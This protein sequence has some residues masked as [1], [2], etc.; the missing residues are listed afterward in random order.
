MTLDVT[1]K[2]RVALVAEEYSKSVLPWVIGFSGGKDSSLVV[3]IFCE[4]LA[5]LRTRRVPVH[6]VYCDTGVEIPVVTAFVRKTLKGIQQESARSNLPIRCHIA[7]PTLSDT[8][9]V[10]LIGRGYPP[11]TNKFRWCTDKLRIRPIQRLMAGVA[12]NEN[13]V[14]LGVRQAE[15]EERKRVLS[16]HSTAEKFYYQQS[17]CESRRLF[18]PIVD[19]D[20]STVWEGLFSLQRPQAIDVYKLGH[21]YKQ[22]GG[23]CPVIREAAGSPCGQGRFGCWT[24][25][26]V[27]KDQAVRGL[28]NEGYASLQP[29]LEYRD[30]LMTIRDNTDYRCTIR[31]NG[32]ATLGPFR[33]RARRK[34]LRRLLTAQ[35]DSGLKLIGAAAIRRI[36]SLWAIDMEDPRYVEDLS[37]DLSF[38]PARNRGATLAAAGR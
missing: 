21:L 29:L 35:R 36:Y 18:C 32:S 14:V 15:S 22:A 20:T 23:E 25:T 17:N 10:R 7:R 11:P 38:E 4:A 19:L 8:F 33:L 24:C 30:W 3:K 16:R 6:I 9:F 2:E 1:L 37:P 27:R 13:I 5:R 12:G 31:R 26:V 28:I 34:L